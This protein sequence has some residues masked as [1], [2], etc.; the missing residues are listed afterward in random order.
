MPHATTPR[1]TEHNG[2]WR[3]DLRGLGG[4]RHD[5]GRDPGRAMESAVG[6]L[7]DARGLALRQTTIET[8]PLSWCVARYQAGD[9]FATMAPG[10][11]RA[12]V[13]HCRA[14]T[15]AL[16]PDLAVNRAGWPTV[17]MRV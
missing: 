4:G 12:V 11:Q 13:E 3:L 10:G 2:R 17:L 16:G 15:A 5:L 8:V 6:L 9:R 14:L 7:A 1:I